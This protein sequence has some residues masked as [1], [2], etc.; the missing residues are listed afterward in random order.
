MSKLKISVERCDIKGATMADGFSCPI[1]RAANR[2][3]FVSGPYRY[4]ACREEM[5]LYA[6][7]AIHRQS[8][9]SRG[10]CYEPLA[11][12]RMSRAGARF[13]D[14]FDAGKKVKPIRLVLTEIPT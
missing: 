14:A 6:V 4:G 12:Y 9:V 8:S 7:S 3:L 13:V 2:R 10:T 5:V 1:A 11:A